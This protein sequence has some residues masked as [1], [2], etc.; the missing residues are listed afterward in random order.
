LQVHSNRF[1]SVL[2]ASI[3]SGNSKILTDPTLIVQEGQQANVNLTSEVVGNITNQNNITSGATIQT[4]TATKENV[5][6]S[7]TIRIERIDDNGFVALSVAPI[8]RAPAGT[9]NIGVGT[10]SQQQIILVS[11]RSLNSGVLRLRDNQ[12]LVLSG[13]IQDSDQST[14]VKVPILGDIP[15]LGALFRSTKKTNQRQEVIVLLT[16]QIIDDS[17]HSS[18]G[19]NYMPSPEVRQLLERR[20][21]SVPKN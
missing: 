11:E 20:G 10:T 21:S 13:I 19:Y 18:I 9:Q 6:L 8:V 14:V 17:V 12:T 7:L 2:Q 1:I 3:T 5:G 4:V 15:I 16:P